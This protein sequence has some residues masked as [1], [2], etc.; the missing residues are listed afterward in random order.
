MLHSSCM[1]Y[2]WCT[3]LSSGNSAEAAVAVAGFPRRNVAALPLRIKRVTFHQ[4]HHEHRLV[5]SLQRRKLCIRP[6]VYE[7]GSTNAA[8][9]ADSRSITRQSVSAAAAAATAA[10]ST[11]GSSSGSGLTVL[12]STDPV[13]RLRYQAILMFDQLD[14]GR[15]GRLLGQD[16][17]QFFT[18]CSRKVS[19][20]PGLSEVLQ[21]VEANCSPL[22][23]AGCNREEFIRVI[24]MQ[25]HAV[26]TSQAYQNSM[27][28]PDEAA[29]L[30]A[31]MSLNKQELAAAKW[32]FGLLDSD[33]DGKVSL[34][35]YKAAEGIEAYVYEDKLEDVDADND[36]YIIFEEFLGSYAKPKPIGKNLIIMAVNTLVVYFILQA[37]F[38][39]TMIK[40]GCCCRG[41][42]IGRSAPSLVAGHTQEHLGCPGLI[43]QL[44]NT[45]QLAPDC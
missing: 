30:Q 44:N 43:Q 21:Q 29:R 17:Q 19:W 7:D 1:P 20:S 9:G 11:S 10:P 4:V 25:V 12:T 15:T 38:L 39:D 16:L 5:A 27:M 33:N 40:V 45:L 42:L 37:P 24:R 41:L 6:T 8:A 36:G 32:M 34:S 2:T 14:Q 31:Q 18:A 13:D 26:S 28:R 22:I 23:A 35:M 3:A